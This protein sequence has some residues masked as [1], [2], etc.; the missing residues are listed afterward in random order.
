[1][2]WMMMLGK[3]TRSR[4][5]IQLIDDLLEQKKYT[6]LKKAAEDRSVWRTVRDCHKLASQADN[7][8]D[9]TVFTIIIIIMIIIITIIKV[10]SYL[11][12]VC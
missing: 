11:R 6:D 7:I 3:R 2:Y 8:I 1:M 10:V 5:R 12:R 4:R 9:C